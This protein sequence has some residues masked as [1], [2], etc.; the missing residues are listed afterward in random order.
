MEVKILKKS[1]DDQI[2]THLNYSNYNYFLEKIIK[3]SVVEEKEKYFLA[4]IDDE[5][6]I[7]QI[8]QGKEWFQSKCKKFGIFRDDDMKLHKTKEKGWRIIFQK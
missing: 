4:T 8:F 2:N 7:R 3:V 5:R 6:L 1:I